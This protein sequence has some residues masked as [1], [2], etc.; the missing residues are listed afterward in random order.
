MSVEIR[1]WPYRNCK[2]DQGLIRS[3]E[4]D[5]DAIPYREYDLWRL[6]PQRRKAVESVDPKASVNAD[7]VTRTIAIQTGDS[8][9][10][11]SKAFADAGYPASAS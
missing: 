6:C 1:A 3:R 2:P 9:A 5:P 7:P 10:A 4:G 8:T 11:L